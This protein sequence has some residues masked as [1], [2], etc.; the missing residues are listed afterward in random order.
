MKDFWDELNLA[1]QST[2][3]RYFDAQD[4]Q[5]L[6]QAYLHVDS[7]EKALFSVEQPIQNVPVYSPFVQIAFAWLSL[8]LGL[9]AFRYFTRLA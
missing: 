4:D 3:G 2:G 7:L 8:S 6:K 9:R 1:L 5:Q